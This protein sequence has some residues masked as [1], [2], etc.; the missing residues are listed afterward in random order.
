MKII[1]FLQNAWSPY[2]AGHEWPRASW[3]RALAKSPTGRKLRLLELGELYHNCYNITPLVG[4]EPSSVLTPDD[5][6]VRQ[7]LKEQKPDVV[8]ACGKHAEQFLAPRWAGPLLAVPHPAYRVVT[9]ELY[10]QAGLILRT[11]L[12]ERVALRQKRGHIT[13][14]TL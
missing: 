13:R 3:L 8:L 6:H 9:N 10:T 12:S 1:I 2:Y 4:M 11:G 7:I 14:E 5:L